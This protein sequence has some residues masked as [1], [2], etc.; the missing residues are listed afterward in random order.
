MR[1]NSIFVTGL[2]VF[3]G[4]TSFIFVYYAVGIFTADNPPEW[5]RV[6]AYVAAGYG[7]GN[8]YILSW[9]WRIRGTGAVWA[10]KLIA[11]C[12]FGVFLLDRWKV[13]VESPLEY[14]GILAVAGIL[15]L[16]WLAVKKISERHTPEVKTTRPRR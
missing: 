12:F 4:L 9:A 14:V 15:L 10:N 11:L 6:L 8:I 16:N 2:A 13:G 1:Q 3:S 7:L 5:S